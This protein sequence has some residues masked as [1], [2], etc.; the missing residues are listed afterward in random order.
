[1]DLLV[2]LIHNCH[3]DPTVGF[4]TKRGPQDEFGKVEE[5]M[6]DMLDAKFH[7]AVADHIENC[8]QNWDMYS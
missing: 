5:E 3:D 7:D 4:E 1:L 6:L 2:P 8:V